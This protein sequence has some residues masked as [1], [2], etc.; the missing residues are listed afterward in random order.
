[1]TGSV[2][3]SDA[4]KIAEQLRLRL[5]ARAG[6]NTNIRVFEEGFS[7]LINQPSVIREFLQK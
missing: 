6:R 7:N 3:K 5:T 1:L 4:G 2:S